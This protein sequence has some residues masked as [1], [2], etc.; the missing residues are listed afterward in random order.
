MKKLKISFLLL[1]LCLSA[2]SATCRAD[3]MAKWPRWNRGESGAVKVLTIQYLLR[4]RGYKLGADGVFGAQTVDRL[5]KF[6]ASRGLRADGITT[7]QTW[8]KLI[9]NLRRGSKGDAVR[10][11]QIQLKRLDYKVA[12]DGSFG[13]QT[14]K[15]VRSFQEDEHLTSDGTV[16]RYTWSHLANMVRYYYDE[17]GNA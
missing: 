3:E 17:S 12:V 13:A 8:E 16:G 15:A 11:L 1:A 10:A 2:F 4:A 7:P 9:V 14:E 6:Q 5:K